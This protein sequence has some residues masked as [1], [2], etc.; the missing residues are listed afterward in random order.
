M[1]VLMHEVQTAQQPYYYMLDLADLEEQRGHQDEAIHWLERA[2][3]ESQGA[4]TRFQWGTDYVFGLIRMRPQDAKHIQDTTINVLSELDGPD[5]IYMR[6]AHR[7]KTL[8]RKLR[9]WNKNGAHAAT[10]TAAR[11]RMDDICGKIPKTEPARQSC[12]VFLAKAS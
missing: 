1:D 3:N 4:A 6:T 12:D 5:R 8:D 7:L 11:K 9:E 10:I 2:Y